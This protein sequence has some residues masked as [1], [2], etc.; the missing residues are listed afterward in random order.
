MKKYC[1]RSRENENIMYNML[2]TIKKSEAKWFGHIL[3]RNCLLKRLID[4]KIEG[5]IEV[6]R[7]RGGRCKEILDDLKGQRRCWKFKEEAPDR[8]PCGTRVEGTTGL[9]RDRLW[10]K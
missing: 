8:L 2:C 9:S 10:N 5:R 6:M 3:S 1:I 4:G 7:R